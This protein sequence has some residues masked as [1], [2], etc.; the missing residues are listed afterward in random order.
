[1]HRVDFEAGMTFHG[2]TERIQKV[3]KKAEAGEKVT[4]AYLGG[5]ITQGSLSSTPD[6]CYASMTT[7]WWKEQYP[8]TEFVSINAGIG[9][10]P[11]QFG[12]ARAEQDVLSYEPDFVIV[13][14]SVND[15]NSLFYRET[16][17]GLVRKLHSSKT[18][19]AVLLVHN[20]F[21]QTGTN[22]QDQHEVI[23]RYY[24]IPCVSMKTSVY[25]S[26]A[27]GKIPVREITPDDLH[28]N[29]AGH[30]M[31]SRLITYF[32]EK[33]QKEAEFAELS[34]GFTTV[35]KSETLPAP[36]T[37]NAYEQSVRYQN[38]NSAPVLKGFAADT[39]E[40][41]HITDIF[42]RGFVGT[43]TGDTIRFTVPGSGV[44]VQ[45]RKSVKHPACVAKA[46]LDGNED[47]AVIL[48]GNFE[49]TWGDCLYITTLLCH[50]E[51][52]EHTLEITITDGGEDKVPFY[53][54]SVIGSR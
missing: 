35:R 8:E 19:P 7:K 46:V 36:M 47:H 20:V 13:E 43:Q 34:G 24:K 5:S 54:V 23:G 40:Q 22:A 38:Y 1:M 4:L 26:V 15:D 2:N 17:E 10:T 28:P 11:S 45:Y 29:D 33:V 31:L 14:F 21:Y 27:E 42:K 37:E 50:G 32:L 12:V 48:D 25:Q 18:N 30:A 39:R 3:L 52:K 9:G 49:E 6:T 51:D 41:T 44:A 53:L 16:Y